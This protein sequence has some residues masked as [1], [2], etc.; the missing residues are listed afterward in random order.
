MLASWASLQHVDEPSCVGGRI[1]VGSP[2]LDPLH[3]ILI[4]THGLGSGRARIISHAGKVVAAS[5]DYP[6]VPSTAMPMMVA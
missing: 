1:S 3:A 4:G 6:L 5:A 2:R